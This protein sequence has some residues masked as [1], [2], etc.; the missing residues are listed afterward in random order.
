MTFKLRTYQD[1]AVET[2]RQ[3]WQTYTDVLAVMATGLGKTA[4]LLSVLH[5][6]LGPGDRGLILAHRKE[7]I[8]QPR[9]RMLDYYPDW[10]GRIGIVMADQDE[11]D[12]QITVAT[13]QTLA[14]EKRLQRLLG[15]GVITHLVIDEAH[16]ATSDTYVQ[17][18]RTLRDYNPKLKHLGVTATPLRSDGAGLRAVYQHVSYKMGIKEGVQQGWLVPPR[19]LAIQTGISLAGVPKNGG[20]Y[21][22]RKLADVYDTANCHTL[23]VESHQKYASGRQALAFTASVDGAYDLAA[24]FNAAGITAAAADANTPKPERANIL[25]AF[26]NGEIAVLCNRFLYTEGL[27]VPEV[28]CIHMVAPTLSDLCY[29]Q[30]L[31]RALR[32]VPGKTDALILDYAPLE[33]RNIVMAGDVLGVEARKDAYIKDDPQEGAVLGGFTFDGKVKWLKGDPMEIVSRQLDYL[34]LSPWVWDRDK[35]GW[36]ILPLGAAE[37]GI[38]RTLAM[39]PVADSMTLYLIAKRDDERYPTPY[40]IK[41]GSFEELSA[42]ADEYA[43]RRGQAILAAKARQW[44]KAPPTDKQIAYAQRLRVF[45]PGMSRGQVAAAITRAIAMRTLKSAGYVEAQHA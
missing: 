4:V 29:T 15:N 19:W 25:R 28:S 23:V 44:R 34:D 40:E 33:A 11:C 12:R 2:I 43:E 18:W 27:D 39:S 17:I 42:W 3:D 7:L 14:S 37:D 41:T 20:D 38:D 13:V 5:R 9:D 8:E 26:R 21:T 6:D 31:G 22:Q 35:S 16:H 10:Q 45:E 30:K 1:Q 24:A 32:P 36:L